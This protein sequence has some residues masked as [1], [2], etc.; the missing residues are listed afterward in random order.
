MIGAET[1]PGAAGSITGSAGNRP[2][3]R[4]RG[5]TQI[6]LKV[7]AAGLTLEPGIYMVAH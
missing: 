7:G 6:L 2:P 5:E 3:V 1:Y 4:A